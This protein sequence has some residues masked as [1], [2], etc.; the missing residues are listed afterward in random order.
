M[1]SDTLVTE[2]TKR[3]FDLDTIVYN[4]R[5]GSG[6]ILFAFVL[7]HLLN[8][9]LG[10]I[11]LDLMEQVQDWRKMVTRHALGTTVLYGALATHMFLALAKTATRNSLRLPRWELVQLIFG[12]TIP[13]LLIL[14]L[15]DTRASNWLINFNDSYRSAIPGYWPKM[16]WLPIALVIVVWTHA[17]MGLHFWLRLKRWYRRRFL[18]LFALA[19]LIPTLAIAG[20]VTAGKSISAER[21]LKRAKRT[22]VIMEHI[23]PASP[24][25]TLA[26]F[27]P[28]QQ[29]SGLTA[30]PANQPILI[31]QQKG[32]W[33]YGKIIEYAK[34]GQVM[35]GAFALLALFTP[36][37]FYLI[38]RRGPKVVVNYPDNRQV[39]ALRGTSLLEISR[40]ARIPHTSVCG[41]RGRCSTCRVQVARSSDPQPPPSEMENKLLHKIKAPNGVRLACQLEPVG[42]LSVTPLVPANK[43]MTSIGRLNP[44]SL[45]I[46]RPIVVLFA[47][48]RG[49]TSLSEDKLPYDTVFLLNEYFNRQQR[50]ISRHGGRID[51]FMGDGIMALFGA[52]DIFDA[53]NKPASDLQTASKGALSA[54]TDMIQT[55]EDMNRDERLALTHPLRMAIGLHAGPA[56]LGDLGAGQA[57]RPTAIGDVVNAAAR[58]ESLAKEWDAPVVASVN[59]LQAAGLGLEGFEPVSVE[60]RGKQ[61]KI[62]VVR[63]D[64]PAALSS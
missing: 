46:E 5:L 62:D 4:F 57:R 7:T 51:K 48:L 52:E 47:D 54:L 9:S 49:F 20:F 10:L 21:A 14:H 38:R 31:A 27:N 42:K 11:S 16:T 15:A 25:L 23:Q 28:A 32:S 6:L 40:Q 61:N 8:H 36:T 44:Q 56:V 34:I 58:L 59:V 43:A 18:L 19:I 53:D 13:M 63:L 1:P 45:G 35:F 50:A 37:A 55:L 29:P 2:Q 64:D 24:L 33:S 39:T 30:P 60:V 12:L 22:D 41:G 26:S 3:Q 17:C